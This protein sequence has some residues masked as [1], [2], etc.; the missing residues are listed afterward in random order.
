[1][2]TPFYLFAVVGFG[3]LAL[4]L[5]FAGEPSRQLTGKEPSENH[6]TS[7]RPADRV[8]PIQ[9]RANGDQTHGKHSVLHQSGLNKAATA[10]TAGLMMNKT[11]SPRE[12]LAS[13]PVGG[14]T[15]A[16]TLARIIHSPTAGSGDPAYRIGDFIAVGRVPLRAAVSA[17]QSVYEIPGPGVVRGR[18]TAAPIIGGLATSSAKCS[19]AVINGTGMKRKP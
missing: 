8:H 1:M 16:P 13:L 11:G 18:G 14:G 9:G 17:F 5:S 12:Q 7:D 19:A 6:T 10:T 15:T 3:A 2:K 4:G